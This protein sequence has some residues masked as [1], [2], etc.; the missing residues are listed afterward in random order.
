MPAYR[1]SRRI[2]D[3]ANQFGVCRL[4]SNRLDPIGLLAL[5]SA[6]AAAAMFFWT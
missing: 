5:L 1:R 4:F 2:L 3:V 6:L